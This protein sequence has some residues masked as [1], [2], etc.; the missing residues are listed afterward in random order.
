MV[1]QGVRVFA[2]PASYWLIPKLAD[3]DSCRAP[4]HRDIHCKNLR[5][6]NGIEAPCSAR[7]VPRMSQCLRSLVLPWRK[8][9]PS[10]RDPGDRFRGNDLIAAVTGLS[11][12][13]TPRRS[14][15]RAATYVRSPTAA[16]DAAGL[17]A[18]D[19]SRRSAAVL[20]ASSKVKS[21]PTHLCR[22]RR[23]VPYALVVSDI[24]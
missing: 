20:I 11:H 24:P 23:P 21:R 15:Y 12:Q 13:P 7:T 17:A 8:F 5:W 4:P 14:A 22:R 6:S 3:P 2:H 19:E 18:F 16:C 1:G 10:C 9:R